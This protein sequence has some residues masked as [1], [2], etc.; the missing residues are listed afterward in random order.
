[1]FALTE[2]LQGMFED[3]RLG[4]NKQHQLV[5]LSRQSIYSRLAGYEDVSDAERL[6]IDPAMRH[7]VGGRAM[8]ADKCAASTSEVGRFETENLST[9]DNLKKLMALSGS[10]SR[11]VVFQMAEV[12]VLRT[13][14]CDIL[15][16][17]AQL[18]ASPELAGA[19]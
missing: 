3:S 15:G 14:S 12:A 5:P 1:M 8:R 18:R 17:I 4:S 11:Y 13:L 19:G 2:M 10:Y 9:K 6:S 7:V 16:R